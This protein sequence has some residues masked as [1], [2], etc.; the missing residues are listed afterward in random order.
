MTWFKVIKS[1]NMT[2][3]EDV[4]LMLNDGKENPT[5]TP[6]PSTLLKTQKRKAMDV[7][8]QE[9]VTLDNKD[10]QS[11]PPPLLIHVVPT[12]LPVPTYP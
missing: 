2:S 11:P 12:K 9:N 7:E 5:L 8:T 10:D 6:T 1:S 3:Q 4:T